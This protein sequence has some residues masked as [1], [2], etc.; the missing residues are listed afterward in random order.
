MYTCDI[1][2]QHSI[3][4]CIRKWFFINANSK[5][6]FYFY[7]DSH[8]ERCVVKFQMSSTSTLW[9]WET[10]HECTVIC[11][12]IF[13][14][15]TEPRCAC[16]Q[17]DC[18]CDSLWNLIETIKIQINMSKNINLFC[19]LRKEFHVAFWMNVR[20][21]INFMECSRRVSEPFRFHWVSLL[22]MHNSRMLLFWAL[23][24]ICIININ[25]MWQLQTLRALV[26]I[27]LDRQPI[28][29]FRLLFNSIICYL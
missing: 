1:H 11:Q 8:M 19:G 9:E 14:V 10:S 28:Y 3:D 21:T 20:S 2:V 26:R 22:L 24:S 18:L 29:S 12:Y 6:D 23:V 25:W 7:N 16:D 5:C 15:R 13:C 17:L 27:G 4:L